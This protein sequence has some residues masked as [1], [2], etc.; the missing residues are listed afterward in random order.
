MTL[1]FDKGLPSQHVRSVYHNFNWYVV[2]SRFWGFLTSLTNIPWPGVA[3]YFSSYV[4]VQRGHQLSEFT[5]NFCLKN[6][7]Y[8]G[9]LSTVKQ[10]RFHED[11]VRPPQLHMPSISIHSLFNG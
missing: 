6:W 11:D 9:H 1:Y 4:A 8:F 2:E 7:K 5:C 3:Q 10:T